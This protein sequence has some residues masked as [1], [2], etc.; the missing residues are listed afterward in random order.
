MCASVPSSRGAPQSLSAAQRTS[1]FGLPA[2]CSAS[3]F[4]P[5]SSTLTVN[6]RD[7]ISPHT[8]DR[9]SSDTSTS[10]GSRETAVN[11]LTVA[12]C[13]TPSSP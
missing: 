8:R 2:K 1:W 6:G 7:S 10:G 5:D 4:C 11:A 3:S 9:R 12:P 13:G